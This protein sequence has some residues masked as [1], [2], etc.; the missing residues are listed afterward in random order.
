MNKNIKKIIALV[1]AFNGIAIMQPLQKIGIINEANAASNI[2]LKSLELSSGKI[3]FDP[4]KSSYEVQVDENVDNLTISAKPDSSI[5]HY[6]QYLVSINGKTI[7]K[8]DNF[9][10]N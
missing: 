7:N 9:E 8:N 3:N 4:Y 6:D 2:Y 1:L 5:S 10:K